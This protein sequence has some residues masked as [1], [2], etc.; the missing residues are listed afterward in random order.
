MPAPALVHTAPGH[1]QEDYE[2]GLKYKLEV[3]NPVGSDGRFVAG[4][5]LFEG[6]RVFEA[7]KH[8]IAVLEGARR[9]AARR[10]AASTAIRIAGVT[11]RR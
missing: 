8:V 4:T 5:P 11:R 9:A 3:D 6:E 7:N 2:V 10:T 1:G